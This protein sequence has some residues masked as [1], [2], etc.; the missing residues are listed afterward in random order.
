MAG[1]RGRRPTR[2]ARWSGGRALA[3]VYSCRV[4]RTV[5]WCLL[6]CQAERSGWW[7]VAE[8]DQEVILNLKRARRFL[9]RLG[10][11]ISTQ[12][13]NGHWTKI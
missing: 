2:L 8:V 13:R 1:G 4:T 12:S 6:L 5:C 9:T 10:K 7:V 11:L 3:S